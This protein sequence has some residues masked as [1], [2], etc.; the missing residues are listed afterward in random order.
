M[1]SIRGNLFT[2]FSLK[3]LLLAALAVCGSA[4]PSFAQEMARGKFTLTEN[5]RLGETLLPPGQYSFSVSPIGLMRSVASVQSMPTPVLVFIRPQSDSGPVSAVF[6]LA[7][8]QSNPAPANGFLI[9]PGPSGMSIHS[10][11]LDKLGVVVDFDAPRE[12]QALAQS[13]RATPAVV[14]KTGK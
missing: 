3:I 13:H 6:A 7:S 5:V 9:E 10:L 14:S 4:A 8:A 2:R 12:G 1:T 11:T